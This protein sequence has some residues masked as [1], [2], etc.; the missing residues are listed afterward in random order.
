MA[1]KTDFTPEEWQTV[2]TSPLYA[3]LLISLADPSGPIGLVKETFAASA[4]VVEG[5]KGDTPLTLVKAIADDI[6]SRN[7]KVEAPKFESVEAG[8]SYAVAQLRSALATVDQKA[9]DEAP[10]F[11]QWL[12]DT[13]QKAAKASKEGGFLGFGGVAVSDKEQTALSELASILGVSA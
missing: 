6:Q 5:A 9:A 7:L 2:A 3:G 1:S 12:Y 8:R 13:A 11:K 4:S 10:R